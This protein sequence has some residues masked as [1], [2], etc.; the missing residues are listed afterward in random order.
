MGGASRTERGRDETVR[1]QAGRDVTRLPESQQLYRRC[2][3][4]RGGSDTAGRGVRHQRA[5]LWSVATHSLV[6]LDCAV[7]ALFRF[8]GVS[9]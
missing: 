8:L 4:R 1:E 7:K 6:W 2:E 9:V 5:L 3:R